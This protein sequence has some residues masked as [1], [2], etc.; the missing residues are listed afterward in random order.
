MTHEVMLVVTD[1]GNCTVFEG[2]FFLDTDS[3]SVIQGFIDR[4]WVVRM[5]KPE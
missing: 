2:K 1:S 5:E 3:L 4:G